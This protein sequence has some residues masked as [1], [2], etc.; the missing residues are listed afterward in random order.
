MLADATRV[1][2][3]LFE[4]CDVGQQMTHPRAV[5]PS[6][7]PPAWTVGARVHHAALSNAI[8]RASVS[9]FG[10]HRLH[11]PSISLM[12]C[13]SSRATGHE[14]G[15]ANTGDGTDARSS[16]IRAPF[17]GLLPCDSAACVA[18]TRSAFSASFSA[19]SCVASSSKGTPQQATW[20]YL[21]LFRL[22]AIGK[23][24]LVHLVV[25]LRRVGGGRVSDDLGWLFLLRVLLVTVARMGLVLGDLAKNGLADTG[26]CAGKRT[27]DMFC[28]NFGKVEVLA[29]SLATA[30]IA[31]G[32]GLTSDD[33]KC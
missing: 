13:S 14:I 24:V 10:P 1:T 4:G 30:V 32:V 8:Q 16:S 2:S 11:L 29:G 20:T 9:R 22:R 3:P 7:Q 12:R 31:H 19:F 27:V 17:D 15:P 25:Q 18:G 26:L 33:C 28:G 5:R 21:L 6:R 23:A